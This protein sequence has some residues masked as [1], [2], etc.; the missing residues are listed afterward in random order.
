M[1]KRQ[2]IKFIP[3]FVIP[4]KAGIHDIKIQNIELD[5]RLRGNDRIDKTK[6]AVSGFCFKNYFIQ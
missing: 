4:A 3:M 6:T 1:I 5:S 2:A